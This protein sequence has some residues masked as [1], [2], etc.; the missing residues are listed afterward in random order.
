MKRTVVKPADALSTLSKYMLVDGFD[1]IV[2]LRKSKGSYI[3]DARSG[4]RY[5]DFFTF[6]ASSPVGMNHPKLTTPEFLAKLGRVAVNKPSNS[7]IYTVEEAEF[8]ATF[9]RVAMPSYLPHAFLVEGG[10]VGVENA[11]TRGQNSLRSS[12]DYLENVAMV[13]S[14]ANSSVSSATNG[15]DNI[16]SSVREQTAV[17]NEIAQ[18][19]EHIA[20]MAETNSLASNETSAAAHHLEQLA[21]KL[22][23]IVGRFKA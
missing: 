4:K 11:I 8:L 17:S 6:V 1:V 5:L 18:H 21:S 10:S 14:E 13:L 22:N 2:D 19:V 23:N 7:D 9:A 16:T 3:V 15:V 20:Q 12:Q